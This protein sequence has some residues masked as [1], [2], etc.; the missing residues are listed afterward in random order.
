M[1]EA[2]QKQPQFL[3][4]V[5]FSIRQ[6]SKELD[7]SSSLER[8]SPVMLRVAKHLAADGERPFAAL[9]VTWCDWSNCQGLFFTFEPCLNKIIGVSLCRGR[10]AVPNSLCPRCRGLAWDV[11]AMNWALRCGPYKRPDDLL[12]FIIGCL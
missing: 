2:H 9:R 4:A 6:G 11:G 10:T 1:V 5:L 12:K 7:S 3:R 8:S